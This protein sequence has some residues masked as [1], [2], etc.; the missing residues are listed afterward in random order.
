MNM[1]LQEALATRKIIKSDST[2]PALW[3]FDHGW[4]CNMHTLT[5]THTGNLSLQIHAGASK[6]VDLP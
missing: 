4:R 3:I 1:R 6:S 5:G 2:T